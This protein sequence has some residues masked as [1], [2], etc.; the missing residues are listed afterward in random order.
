MEM[1]RTRVLQ[2][3]K[4]VQLCYYVALAISNTSSGRILDLDLNLQTFK[5]V[6]EQKL[7]Q[8]DLELRLTLCSR[9]LQLYYWIQFPASIDHVWWSAFRTVRENGQT[10]LLIRV[11]W[12]PKPCS[13]GISQRSIS[14]TMSVEGKPQR[15]G[16]FIHKKWLFSMESR[17]LGLEVHN[18]FENDICREYAV[19]FNSDHYVAMLRDCLVPKLH[20][21][22]INRNDVG[23]QQS[24]E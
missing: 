15:S 20:K 8:R 5:I 17:G 19:F 23:F 9:L 4:S 22:G 24:M 11:T 3:P 6:I 16:Y 13:E 21:L 18:F 12:K 14:Q 10:K 7:Y 2:S 1:V